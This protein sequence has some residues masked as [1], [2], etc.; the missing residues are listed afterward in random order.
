MGVRRARQII[1]AVTALE[2]Q[3]SALVELI[4]TLGLFFTAIALQ[5]ERIAHWHHRLADLEKMRWHG[6]VL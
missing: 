6:E 4:L 2:S 5:R 3:G 1:T